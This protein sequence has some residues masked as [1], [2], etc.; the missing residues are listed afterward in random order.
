MKQ[1]VLLL[2][3]VL[4]SDIGRPSLPHSSL[5]RSSRANKPVPVL[6]CYLKRVG[7]DPGAI[8]ILYSLAQPIPPL[9]S[10]SD[11]KTSNS[12]THVPASTPNVIVRLYLI[13]QAAQNFRSGPLFS[14]ADL[15]S[16]S[17]VSPLFRVDCLTHSH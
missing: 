17:Q 8:P 16:S 4:G 2:Y 14:P 12:G 11:Y 1:L 6:F 3:N 10:V 13:F 5:L 9:P 15:S 7:P